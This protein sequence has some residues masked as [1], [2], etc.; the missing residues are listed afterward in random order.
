MPSTPPPKTANGRAPKIGAVVSIVTALVAAIPPIVSSLA[1][2]KVSASGAGSMAA[3]RDIHNTNTTINIFERWADGARII[4]G[5]DRPQ[6]ASAP[7][8]SGGKAGQFAFSFESV[9]I[10]PRPHQAPNMGVQATVGFDITNTSAKPVRVALIPQ[11]PSL[12]AE[13]GITFDTRPN[14]VT[15]VAGFNNTSVQNCE[16]GAP[17]FSL[18]RPGESIRSNIVLDGTFGGRDVAKISWARFSGSL[19]V[20]SVDDKTCWIEVLSSAKIPA[21]LYK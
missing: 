7:S 6:S 20:Q 1:S 15:G 13:G 19:M 3:G 21:T 4:T 16:R 8:S 11:W 14:G 10:S 17:N 12:Q 2:P 9:E 18:L 5:A